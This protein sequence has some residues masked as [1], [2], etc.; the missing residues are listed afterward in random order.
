MGRILIGRKFRFCEEPFVD[1]T[2]RQIL[3][4]IIL[5]NTQRQNKGTGET[6]WL[7][8]QAIQIAEELCLTLIALTVQLTDLSVMSAIRNFYCLIPYVTSSP[9]RATGYPGQARG[10]GDNKDS[11]KL[12]GNGQNG[13]LRGTVV[14]LS[15]PVRLSVLEERW[16][17][18]AFLETASQRR[19]V[20]RY[21]HFSETMRKRLPS[22]KT[23]VFES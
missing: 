5:R 12:D 17:T 15:R 1:F 14:N 11:R 2:V 16:E 8:T 18:A 21:D 4:S 10:T 13:C 7:F 6:S 20:N 3:E 19:I 23:A 9:K 22:E